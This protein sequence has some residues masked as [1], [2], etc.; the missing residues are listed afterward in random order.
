[1]G[2]PDTSN[3]AYILKVI[4]AKENV[5]PGLDINWIASMTNGY[6]GSDLKVNS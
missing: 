3:R 5:S 2:L 6:S 4:L 1:M